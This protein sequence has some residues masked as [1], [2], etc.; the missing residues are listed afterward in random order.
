MESP[1]VKTF[2]RLEEQYQLKDDHHAEHI[3]A[4]EEEMIKQIRKVKGREVE[5][6]SDKFL[7]NWNTTI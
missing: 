7:G 6:E 1:K 3:F 4:P 2:N 5:N